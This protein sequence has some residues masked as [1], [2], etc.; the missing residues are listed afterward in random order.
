MVSPARLPLAASAVD[1]RTDAGPVSG[2]WLG[3]S[4]A[5]ILEGGMRCSRCQQDNP[6]ATRRAPLR[7]VRTRDFPGRPRNTP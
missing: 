1:R 7:R 4:A 3:P 5:E 6:S 2:P